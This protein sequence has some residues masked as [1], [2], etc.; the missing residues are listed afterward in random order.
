[1]RSIAREVAIDTGS[2]TR[3]RMTFEQ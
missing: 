3:V 2:G 1:M